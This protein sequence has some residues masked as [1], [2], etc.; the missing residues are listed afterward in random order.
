MCLSLNATAAHVKLLD[1]GLN[2]FSRKLHL[3]D[4]DWQK[5]E[6]PSQ[7][8]LSIK[9][10]YTYVHDIVWH[11]HEKSSTEKADKVRT[12]GLKSNLLR[13]CTFVAD[14]CILCRLF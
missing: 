12:E 11:T 4:A 13:V 1:S 10:P 7:L 5:T 14:L 9:I 8:Y 6:H 3:V 2:I